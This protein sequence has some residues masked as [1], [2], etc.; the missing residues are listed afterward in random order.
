VWTA[1]GG[2]ID[3]A[4]LFTAGGDSGQQRIEAAASGIVGIAAVRTTGTATLWPAQNWVVATPDE[5][6]LDEAQLARARDHALTG[7]G[8]GFIARG[9]RRV[10]TWG[11][12]A[13][14]YDVKSTTKSIG[15]TVLG[16]AIADAR[17]RFDDRAQAHLAAFGLPPDSNTATGWLGDITLGHLATQTAGFAKPG[18]YVA[19][20]F[21]PGSRWSYSDGGANWLADVLTTVYGQD[22]QEVLFSRVLSRMNITAADLTWRANAARED[23]L[24]G[25]KRREL[26]SG[27]SLDVDAMARIGYLYLRRGM[28]NGERLL[29][30]SFVRQIERPAPWA[31]GLPVNV[32]AE[33]DGASSRYGALWWT[34]ADGRLADVPREAFWA[35]GLGDSLIVVI[36]SLDLVIAR[37][38][39][40]WRAGWDANY[41]VL[42]PF[43]TPIV[44]A[45]QDNAPPLVSAGA[46]ISIALPLLEATL[47]GTVSDDGMPGTGSLTALWRLKSGDP[48]EI[49]SPG[50]L[51]TAVRF[52][53]AGAYTLELTVSDGAASAGDEVNVVVLGAQPTLT[54]TA[55][56]DRVAAGATVTLNWSASHAHSCTASNGWSGAKGPAGAEGVTVSQ[57]STYALACAGEGG[58]V[59][60]SVT[61]T[62]DGGG[63]GSGGGGGGGSL[64]WVGLAALLLLSAS[65]FRLPASGFRLPAGEGKKKTD[66]R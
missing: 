40:G 28:W 44:E 10:F 39:E 20:T 24:N 59:Q 30:E 57:T 53:H 19:L 49:A 60:S 16:L 61:V 3:A 13:T 17:V 54:L 64:G 66:G 7:G 1:S 45:V 27:I 62:A 2:T 56:A 23:T 25:V 35:W 65:G 42:E 12:L 11:D 18:G 63:S 26:A 50:M 32:P 6:D 15:G 29:P 34:N 41:D 58:S 38:G 36:P 31:I 33:F 51:T 21:A 52:P 37:A 43:L 9:G 4:G 47:S 14:R 5:A 48:V 22:L 46:D 55:S 8:S